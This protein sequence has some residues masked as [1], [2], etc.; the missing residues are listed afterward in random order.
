MTKNRNQGEL[1]LIRS[2]IADLT[3]EARQARTGAVLG[4]GIVAGTACMGMVIGGW[5]WIVPVILGFALPELWKRDRRVRTEIAR[6]R[7]RIEALEGVRPPSV[8]RLLSD[9]QV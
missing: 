4:T 1:A 8:R 9:G 6:R 7:L 3:N 5:T 2:E